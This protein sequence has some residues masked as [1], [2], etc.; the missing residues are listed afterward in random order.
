[1][2]AVSNSTNPLTHFDPF[3]LQGG[4]FKEGS[5]AFKYLL[6]KTLKVSTVYRR[7]INALLVTI[8]GTLRTVAKEH[9]NLS[10]SFE[11]LF[12]YEHYKLIIEDV[13][14]H[15]HSEVT[16]FTSSAHPENVSSIVLMPKFREQIESDLKWYEGAKEEIDLVMSCIA[17]TLFPLKPIKISELQALVTKED[18]I[19]KL[20]SRIGILIDEEIYR[21]KGFT[22]Y[23]DE[24]LSE[25]DKKEFGNLTSNKSLDHISNFAFALLK[26]GVREAADLIFKYTH[27]KN[28]AFRM[29]AFTQLA[30]WEF[31]P[32]L[33][34]EKGDLVIQFNNYRITCMSVYTTAGKAI[35]KFRTDQ[36]FFVEHPLLQNSGGPHVMFL[37]R[38]AK[39]EA[40]DRQATKS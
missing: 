33:E 19:D 22:I 2:T 26:A 32:Q 29:A 27:D 14:E 18:G 10:I 40:G 38:A 5:I 39:S 24:I 25:A 15:V 17:S 34:P 28:T 7:T 1:M 16:L 12:Q 11:D 21:R 23:K 31:Q 8:A 30:K 20:Y 3:Y 13:F 36:P 9:L 35:A 4:P 37:R 6:P